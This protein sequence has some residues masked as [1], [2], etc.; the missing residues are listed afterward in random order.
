MEFGK[1]HLNHLEDPFSLLLLPT[2]EC[3]TKDVEILSETREIK[4]V[5]TLYRVYDLNICRPYLVTKNP[6]P[7]HCT[8][9]GST[10]NMSNI[11]FVMANIY[12]LI[13]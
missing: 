9:M 3:L 1:G 8:K 13:S 7:E 6:S 5:M 2:K 10:Y 11:N 12:K 4:T